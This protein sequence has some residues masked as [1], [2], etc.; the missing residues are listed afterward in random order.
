MGSQD[1]YVAPAAPV[2]RDVA[3]D[4]LMISRATQDAFASLFGVDLKT[5]FPTELASWVLHHV[6]CAALTELQCDLHWRKWR[7]WSRALMH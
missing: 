5:I 3:V 4:E 6:F 2:A 1:E 7:K